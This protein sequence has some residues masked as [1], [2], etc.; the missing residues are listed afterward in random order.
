MA[1]H[2]TRVSVFL[3]VL[4]LIASACEDRAPT[5]P[6][7]TDFHLY[8]VVSIA[9]SSGGRS[10][11]S[12]ARVSLH[13]DRDGDRRVSAAERVETTTDSAGAYSLRY[14]L[15]TQE[16]LVLTVSHPESSDGLRTL[17]AAPGGDLEL[18]IELA[19]LAPFACERGVCSSSDGRLQVRG[20][21]EDI[22]A[23]GRSFDPTTEAMFFPGAFSDSEGKLLVS[24]GFSSVELADAAGRSVSTLTT[25][26]ELRMILSR[27][28]WPIITDIHPNTGA[29][30]YPLYGFD[31]V[32]GEWV[33]EGEG[34]L[35]SEGE[36]I[37]EASLEAIRQGRYVRDV[38]AVAKVSHFSFWNVDWPIES[39]GCIT[40]VVVD[41]NDRPIAGA[42]VAAR[43]VSYTGRSM[44]RTTGPDG[45]FCTEA[46][47]SEAPGQ[48]VDLDGQPGE[49][50]TVSIVAAR[51]GASAVHTAH[52]PKEQ[53]ECGGRCLDVGHLRLVTQAG[54]TTRC[55]HQRPCRGR[56]GAA[57]PRG[58]GRRLRRRR[59]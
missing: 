4:S 21:P 16:R 5:P 13:R 44:P 22:A 6:P 24:G 36:P 10:P 32:S 58:R 14:P 3:L 25:P 19:H 18:G 39:F 31:E 43:G 54:T 1:H 17:L 28:T 57:H 9:D 45:R 50:Q 35:E 42:V 15:A 46:M 30:E 29:I 27:S 20:L 59:R 33:R 51:G 23:R 38:W 40:G 48:D 2:A 26:A 49:V 11:M 12:G 52:M 56:D 8:G 7:A 53:G 41:E 34:V 47:R 55:R 37:P